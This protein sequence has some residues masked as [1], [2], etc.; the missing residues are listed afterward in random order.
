MIPNY[1]NLTQLPVGFT[2][3]TLKDLANY[4]FLRYAYDK[5]KNGK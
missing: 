2:I 5:E 1:T 4:S 3:D